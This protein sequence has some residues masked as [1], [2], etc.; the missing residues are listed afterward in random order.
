LI[1]GLAVTSKLDGG[2]AVGQ[3]TQSFGTTFNYGP[4]D[5][6]GG[7]TR[8]HVDQS[9]PMLTYQLGFS[10]TPPGWVNWARF[11]FGY[12][13]EYWWDVGT[14]G[15]SRT[16]FFSNSIYFRGEINF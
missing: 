1:P 13:F 6:V 9:V 7:A 10:Y 14:A 2:V 4:G 16:D 5:E 12:Q 15:N 11:G 8:Y 3:I